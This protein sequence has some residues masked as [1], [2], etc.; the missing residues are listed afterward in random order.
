[1]GNFTNKPNTTFCLWPTLCRAPETTPTCLGMAEPFRLRIQ[2]SHP[3]EQQLIVRAPGPDPKIQYFFNVMAHWSLGISL[4]NKY[5]REKYEILFRVH[6][7]EAKARKGQ[8][9]PS[10]RE[11]RPWAW[12]DNR[13]LNFYDNKITATFAISTSSYCVSV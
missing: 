11:Y 2:G 13:Y 10:H 9:V 6:A 12:H 7:R 8:H 3:S 5:F 1:M 4:T